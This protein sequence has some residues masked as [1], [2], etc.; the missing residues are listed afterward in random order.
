MKKLVTII[1]SILVCFLVGFISS[2]F[3]ENSIQSWYPFLN[4]SVLNPPNWAFPVAWGILY[5]F[6]GLS[7][8][9]L[10]NK[11]VPSE[12]FFIKL[13]SLQLLLNFTWSITFFYLQNPLLGLINIVLLDLLILIYAIKVYKESKVS[14]L[15][16]VPYILWVTFAAYLNLYI[17]LNN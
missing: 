2:K 4:K 9:L 3:Q 17:L 5:V 14:S 16:F 12:T 7:I 6:M 13:F 8:G 1:I 15:L 11:K 10:I